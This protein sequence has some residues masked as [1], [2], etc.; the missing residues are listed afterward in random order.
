MFDALLDPTCRLTATGQNPAL[1]SAG[2]LGTMAIATVLLYNHL[3]GEGFRIIRA[4]L[5]TLYLM[6]VLA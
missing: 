2:S 4:D 1:A 6:A 5:G 3:T